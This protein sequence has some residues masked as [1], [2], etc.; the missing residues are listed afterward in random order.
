MLSDDESKE[1]HQMADS[2]AVVGVVTGVWDKSAYYAVVDG[3]VLPGIAT[4]R[5]LIRAWNVP[6]NG[7]ILASAS[8][9]GSILPSSRHGSRTFAEGELNL[10]CVRLYIRSERERGTK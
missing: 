4:Q 6:P 2:P 9:A 1:V 8:T 5:Q 10:F 3:K 7:L